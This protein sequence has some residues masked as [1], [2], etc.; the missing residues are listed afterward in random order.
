M[1]SKQSRVTLT[2]RQGSAWGAYFLIYNS[3]KERD[4]RQVQSESNDSTKDISVYSYTLNATIAGVTTIT[5]TNPL[6]LIKTRMCLQYSVPADAAAATST[7]QP[8]KYRSSWHAFR[9]LVQR[10]G[11]RGLY[12]GIVPGY[13]GTLNGTIQMVSYDLMKSW[14]RR[15]LNSN[16]NAPQSEQ[17]LDSF[18][19][20][21]F[22][23]L[24]KI[25]AVTCT[26]PFQLVRARLQDQ[27]RDYK[28]GLREV[29]AKTFKHEGI[30]GFYKGLL[31]CL[32]RVTPAAS[33]TFIV[34]ENLLIFLSSSSS[35]GKQ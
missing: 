9:S 5:L 24:S 27:H 2:S 33:L 1:L 23:G 21:L 16:R 7:S 14:W 6:F 26:Y 11:F 30:Y 18:H 25:L 32:L 20:T 10:D 13:F 3:L 35:S 12:K 17:S 19:Y 28:N 31:P 34:Y 22:S 15:R 29:V 8:V 4:R